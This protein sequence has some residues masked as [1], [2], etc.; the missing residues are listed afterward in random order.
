MDLVAHGKF[1]SWR[2]WS[3]VDWEENE[4]GERVLPEIN[5]RR[6]GGAE[7]ENWRSNPVIFVQ[8]MERRRR[9]QEKHLHRR[10]LVERD[11]KERPVGCEGPFF[12][13]GYHRRRVWGVGIMAVGPPKARHVRGAR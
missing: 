5:T 6:G 7:F 13:Q 3:K 9:S 2:N 1:V 4:A 11:R 10:T 8:H 12:Q